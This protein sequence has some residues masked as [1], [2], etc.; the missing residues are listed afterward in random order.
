MFSCCTN[1]S[2]VTGEDV[3]VAPADDKP[4]EKTTTEA[5]AAPVKAPEPVASPAP[6]PVQSAPP[7]APAA[8]VAPAPPPVEKA[9]DGS[10]RFAYT[11]SRPD[12]NAQWG[13]NLTSD[14]EK[15]LTIV[16]ITPDGALGQCNAKAPK[17][18][19][20][21]DVIVSIE[22]ATSKPDMVSK[23]K[24]EKSLQAEVVRYS[25][26]DATITKSSPQEHLN[27]DVTE[28]NGKL[29]IQKITPKAN[30][31]TRHNMENYTKP[32]IEG[33]YIVAVNGKSTATDMVS[34]IRSGTT[35]TLSIQRAN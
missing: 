19:K 20:A 27:M 21:G 23:L 33:D 6:Q 31:V 8:P 1:S 5:P 2:A 15:S 12:Q 35:F 10:E 29:L 25:A 14:S 28:S 34:A 11:L 24:T 18:R 3:Q 16:G 32:L 30:A 7:P 9:S 17:P 26:F 13:V 4:E 22:K